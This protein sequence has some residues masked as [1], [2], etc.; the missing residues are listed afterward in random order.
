MRHTHL[1]SVLIL[2]VLGM[3]ACGSSATVPPSPTQVPAAARLPAYTEPGRPGTFQPAR[4][5]FVLPEDVREGEDVECGYLSVQENREGGGPASEGRVIQLAV[6]VFHPPGGATHPDPVIYLSGG[7][8][9]S[10]LELFR[11]GS[12]EM[13]R[14]IYSVGR[15]LVVFDQRGVGLSRPA[16]DCPG[17]DDLS[18]ELIDRRI[19]DQ[20]VTEEEA[21]ELFWETLLACRDE[22]AESADLSAYHSAASADD[23][24]DLRRALGAQQ[25]N[26]W[27]GSYGTRLAL[28]VMRRHPA[29]LRSVVLEAVYPPDVDLYVE[30]PADFERALDRLFE[31]CAANE[32]CAAA[33]PD[34]RG[35]FF[36]LVE[37]LSAAP[38]LREVED[39]YTGETYRTWMN[40]NT[41]LGLTFQLLYDSRLRYLL[42]QQI[43]AASQGDYRA[44]DLARAS[45]L[46]MVDVSS[47][48]MM[49]SVQCHEEL[50]FSSLEAQQ[51]ALERHPAVRGMYTDS[52]VG[53]LAYR[54]CQE[55]GAGRADASANE[56]VSSD[57]PVLLMAGEFDPITPPDWGRRAAETLSHG[58]FFEYPGLGHGAV[59]AADC[60]QAMFIEFLEDPARPPVSDCIAGMR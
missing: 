53:G 6:A 23:V 14:P 11:Y 40:G 13:T 22:L 19:D 41:I 21:G 55:W 20:E 60:P 31:A 45:I 38:I 29:G 5:P 37:R 35:T 58:Y 16:L 10:A 56:A 32:V 43:T 28:E 36:D 2:S 3:T 50:A 39:P 25:I 26:L 27:G 54:V 4:C 12:D 8:G 18:R 52:I 48:G 17:F 44:F 57:L 49:F 51:A 15:D 1:C 9:G 47:R 42:P 30:S 7:P 34:L 24:E 46:R 59:A 33:Y